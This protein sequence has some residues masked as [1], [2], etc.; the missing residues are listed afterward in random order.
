MGRPVENFAQR[1]VVVKF[2][3]ILATLNSFR[4]LKRMSMYMCRFVVV[5]RT[6]IFVMSN[7]RQNVKKVDTGGPSGRDVQGF[8]SI[9]ALYLGWEALKGFIS[10]SVERQ[11]PC[12]SA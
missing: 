8:S 7:F 6:F 1:K 4:Y 2:L 12:G 5:F 11:V 3:D 9:Q 10:A